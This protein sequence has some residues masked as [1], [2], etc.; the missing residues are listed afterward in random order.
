[1]AALTS[2]VEPGKPKRTRVSPSPEPGCSKSTPGV[3][4]TPASSSSAS[5][6]RSESRTP[7][8]LR[9]TYK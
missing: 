5:H 2:S 8:D 4:A 6:K 3:T 7:C 9:S 1:M